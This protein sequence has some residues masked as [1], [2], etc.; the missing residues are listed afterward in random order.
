[1]G[2]PSV[3]ASALDLRDIRCRRAIAYVAWLGAAPQTVFVH[4]RLL[5]ASLYCVR[6]EA[7][8]PPRRGALGDQISRGILGGA[9]F[10]QPIKRFTLAN[11]IG[12]RSKVAAGSGPLNGRY[13]PD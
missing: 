13:G 8:S 11:E 1:M 4:D 9:C 12:T 6:R 7:L 5:V 10:I 2:V 3:E